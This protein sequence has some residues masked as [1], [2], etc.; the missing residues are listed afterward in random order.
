MLKCLY[1]TRT[2]SNPNK[3]SRTSADPPPQPDNTNDDSIFKL[4]ASEQ[5]RPP[6]TSNQENDTKPS[7][8]TSP[9]SH[10]LHATTTACTTSIPSSTSFLNLI[11][12]EIT[13]A[14]DE[15]NHQTPTAHVPI[16][17]S[18]KTKI[19]LLTLSPLTGTGLKTCQE[20]SGITSFVRCMHS[21]ASAAKGSLATATSNSGLDSSLGAR[22]HQ[23]TMHWQHPHLPWLQ[24]FPRNARA[25]AD[26][27]VGAAE[28][29]ALAK[30]WTNS[31]RA[32]FQLLRA[33]QCAYFYVCANSYTVLFCAAGIG[34]RDEHHAY[35][36]P[37][38]R[39][40]RDI[41]KEEEIVFGMPLKALPGQKNANSSHNRSLD[42]GV[43]TTQ[44][45]PGSSSFSNG[46][47]E[48]KPVAGDGSDDDEEEE[49]EDQDE[50]LASM[51][52]D[53]AEIRKIG[54]IGARATRN[55]E[56]V[57]DFSD[58]S[59]ALIEG[60]EC[61]AFF[62]Y[63]L[64]SKNTIT[65]TGRLAGVPPTLLA[66]VAFPG[67]TLRTMETRASRIR[68]D[69]E[70]YHSLELKG[71]VLPHVLPYLCG[72]MRE[73]KDTFSA[74]LTGNAGTN[75]FSRAAQ[76]LMEGERENLVQT[77]SVATTSI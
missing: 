43:E 29:E 27:T 40:M 58:H 30:D 21:S 35:V 24:L 56:C 49:D 34:G 8:S 50:W 7:S 13:A 69:G 26:F 3:R 70:E 42:S 37:T 5:Q 72:L 36:T 39:G 1:S 63:L 75:A 48:E 47:D 62:N 31:F 59:L 38:T 60:F 55:N 53:E 68:M 76:R 10:P 14:D 6:R 64:S 2:D 23:A 65:R 12:P 46:S 45:A 19:R 25:N 66:P 28:R 22:F 77:K 71:V 17:W 41:L 73:S 16:D 9:N 33:R 67:A 44:S 54:A 11:A 52:V 18:L 32:L 20:A 74:S 57:D 51:G 4:L 61:Q 15:A